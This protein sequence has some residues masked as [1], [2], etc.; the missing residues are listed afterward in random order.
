MSSKRAVL[1]GKGTAGTSGT[2]GAGSAGLAERRAADAAARP[3][4]FGG[5]LAAQ[6]AAVQ[7]VPTI[8]EECTKKDEF[9]RA[10]NRC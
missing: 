7:Q 9:Q 4:A 10:I 5:T 2:T 3:A 8:V 1:I 6:A